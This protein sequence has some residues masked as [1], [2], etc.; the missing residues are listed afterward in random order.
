MIFLILLGATGFFLFLLCTDLA[1]N[2]LITDGSGFIYIA[3]QMGK[4][5]VL[6]RDIFMTNTPLIPYIYWIYKTL[7]FGNLQ[8]FYLTAII[9]IIAI[10]FVLFFI[11]KKLHKNEF[12][13]FVT[14]FIYLTSFTVISNKL[15]TGITTTLLMLTSAYLLYLN[16]KLIPSGVLVGLALAAKAYTLPI[17]LAFW[18]NGFIVSRKKYLPSFITA[19]GTL[20][21]VML[22]TM[23]LAFPQFLEQTFGYSLTRTPGRSQYIAFVSF[24]VNDWHIVLL[25]ICALVFYR[26]NRF[27][28]LTS[29]LLIL[30]FIL[31]QDRHFMYYTLFVPFGVLSFGYLVESMGRVFPQ[32]VMLTI[33]LISAVLLAIWHIVV[34]VPI[35]YDN[36]RITD[37]QAILSTIQKYNPDYLYGSPY[38]TQGAS[39]LSGVPMLDNMADTNAALFTAGKYSVDHMTKRIFE[40]R[41]LVLIPFRTLPNGVKEY[42]ESV[43]TNTRITECTIVH[44][45]TLKWSGA[46][47]LHVLKCYKD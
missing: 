32:R 45:Q 23:L 14:A 39:Y 41:T 24:V 17:V 28:A 3:Q 7:L 38:V 20:A 12:T 27:L 42:P 21:I 5:Y 43:L 40:T 34:S 19:L 47:E 9:E 35:S 26:K 31:Y 6:Y 18:I 10:A 1:S 2:L 13:A 30:F 16:K 4:G 22:P 29:A 11:A 44:R 46:Q 25:N 36:N 8:A 37:T 33:S 15:P